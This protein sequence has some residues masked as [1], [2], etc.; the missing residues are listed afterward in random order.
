VG[1]LEQVDDAEVLDLVADMLSRGNM[2]DARFR[3]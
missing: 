3:R 1:L 2:N